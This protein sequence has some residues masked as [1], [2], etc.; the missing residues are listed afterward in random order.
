MA[1]FASTKTL[2]STPFSDFFRNASPA[3]K[4]RVYAR[5][6]KNATERQVRLMSRVNERLISSQQK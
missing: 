3:E 5:V 4:K 1:I 2:E 6:M